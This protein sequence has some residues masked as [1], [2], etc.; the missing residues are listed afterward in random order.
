MIDILQ[1]TLAVANASGVKLEPM[2]GK[3]MQKLLGGGKF[4]AKLKGFII[5]PFAIKK[6]KKLVSVITATDF[7]WSVSAGR[8]ME[9]YD[10]L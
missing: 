1:E 3:D 6:H 8:Y 5:L 9:M 4:S 10:S 2:Q 7:S